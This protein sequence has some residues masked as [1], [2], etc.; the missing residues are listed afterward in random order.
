MENQEN[1]KNEIKQI[2]L[3]L[4]K[5]AKAANENLRVFL[6]DLSQEE[7]IIRIN[8]LN[9]SDKSL[10]FLCE[11]IALETEDYEICMA[12]EAIKK[13]RALKRTKLKEEMLQATPPVL[14]A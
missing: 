1:I 6:K 9:L 12:V 7:M 10:N 8:Q 5:H 3:E 2:F 11:G 14:P 13:E 4:S